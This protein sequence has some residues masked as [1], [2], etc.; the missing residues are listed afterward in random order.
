MDPTTRRN[1]LSIDVNGFVRQFIPYNWNAQ[2]YTNYHRPGYLLTYKRSIGCSALRFGVGGLYNLRSDTGGY[3]SNTNNTDHYWR[4]YLRA[5]W[6]RRWLLGPRWSCFTGIDGQFGTGRGDSHNIT[7]QAGQPNVHS[8][9]RS[10]GGGPVLGIRF[11]LTRRISL[12]TEASLYWSNQETGQYCDYP[13]DVNDIQSLSATG[14]ILLNYPIVL[15]CA[16]AF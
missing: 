14:A 4:V 5:G 7:T 9:F 11:Q 12:Y 15:C 16:V 8:T 10:Y 1:E 3:N 6:E 2:G 13:D